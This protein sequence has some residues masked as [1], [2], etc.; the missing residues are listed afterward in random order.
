MLLRHVQQ[1]LEGS[2]LPLAGKRPGQ[3]K[4]FRLGQEKFN[5]S[6]IISHCLTGHYCRS[7]GGTE[8]KPNQEHP[9][10]RL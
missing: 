1:N 9:M 8:L 5:P 7:S 6:E 10:G 3:L 4:Y 2:V